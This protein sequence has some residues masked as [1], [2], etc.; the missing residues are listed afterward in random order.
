M[1]VRSGQYIHTHICMHTYIHAYIHTRIHGQM[2]W[3][4]YSQCCM[5][6]AY[7]HTYIHTYIQAWSDA[8]DSIFI[9]KHTHIHT[10]IHTCIHTGMVRC[11][12]QHIH[13]AA[14]GTPMALCRSSKPHASSRKLHWKF[15]PVEQVRF[16]YCVCVFMCQYTNLCIQ[17]HV[18]LFVCMYVCIAFQVQY[19]VSHHHIHHLYVTHT[20]TIHTHTHLHT[21]I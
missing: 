18:C 16:F 5:W 8:F 4:A 13:S 17:I 9:V 15:A 6:D 14:C 2:L 10:H 7:T 1:R 11:S 12:G 21:L 20:H 3:T 19:L